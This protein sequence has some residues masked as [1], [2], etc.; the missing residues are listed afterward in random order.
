MNSDDIF[1]PKE[2]A[3]KR[4]GLSVRRMLDYAQ[5][6]YIRRRASVD[7]A[8]HRRITVVSEADILK[9]KAELAGGAPMPAASDASTALTFRPPGELVPIAAPVAIAP[10]AWLT[11]AEAAEVSGLPASHLLAA[12]QSEE[13]PARDV[14]VR[15][16]GRYRVKR[17]DLDE[18]AGGL[19]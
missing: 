4:L 1:I 16:G 9:L 13:L 15:P 11:V 5:R 17:S 19:A 7:P 3:A 8:N 2:A 12:I 6:G 18:L 10:R 14:G